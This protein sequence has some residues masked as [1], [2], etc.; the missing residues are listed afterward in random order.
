MNR[1]RCDVL[2]VIMTVVMLDLFNNIVFVEASN[3]KERRAKKTTRHSNRRRSYDRNLQITI[4]PEQT[5]VFS[6][7]STTS[8]PTTSFPTQ[9]P[10]FTNTVTN[11]GVIDSRSC[12]FGKGRT[13]SP[14][15]RPSVAPSESPS[16]SH[17][18]TI[19]FQPSAAPTISFR[20]ST[21]PSPDPTPQPSSSPS[22]FPTPLPSDAPSQRPT[23]SSPPTII[24][25]A[26]PSDKPSKSPTAT[27]TISSQPTI[28]GNPSIAPVIDPNGV[29]N[30][31][32]TDSDGQTG[33]ETQCRRDIPSTASSITDQLI[34]YEYDLIT[35]PGTDVTFTTDKIATE[36]QKEMSNQFLKCTF[37]NDATTTFDTHTI[38][39]L[40]VDVAATTQTNCT[41]VDGT[42]ADCYRINA[43][44]TATIF[45]LHDSNGRRK[46]QNGTD[47]TNN[48]TTPSNT[49]TTTT[50][51]TTSS[52]S[53]SITDPMV[54]E[55]FSS[56]LQSVFES[57]RLT[58][59]ITNVKST[60]FQ[61]IVNDDS[62][63]TTT[64]DDDSGNTT[65][66]DDDSDTG[67]Q[68]DKSLSGGKVAGSVIGTLI[69]V[70]IIAA[71]IAFFV[72]RR[73]SRDDNNNTKNRTMDVTQQDFNDFVKN[74][75]YDDNNDRDDRAM[76]DRSIIASDD[77]SFHSGYVEK[78]KHQS[79]YI[80]EE[81]DQD[82]YY[83]R[84]FPNASEPS[85]GE[86]IR[87]A[88]QPGPIFVKT[89]EVLY[90]LNEAERKA[91][92]KIDAELGTSNVTVGSRRDYKAPDTVQL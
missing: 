73:H 46:L 78:A 42:T 16:I 60:E 84:D 69:A 62:G 33:I 65:T 66:P 7:N 48:S 4:F 74:E 9:S 2:F 52:P 6:T 58:S 89:N 17:M 68:S 40:P 77:G 38:S 43:A 90:E 32:V 47:T 61:G 56:S 86:R 50:T 81:D 79:A 19:S 87:S 57:G 41:T 31:I 88:S 15:S 36:I 64:P 25:S 22:L 18:P 14:S 1:M 83:T 85:F 54:Y 76:I 20:P 91:T 13:C 30:R 5:T 75:D 10:V 80:I 55:S 82:T 92:S 11:V 23:I 35:A 12:K 72:L 24:P 49:T 37:D 29:I 70:A 67:S 45:Y 28:T 26:M 59:D 27:P 53:D 51:T 34:V 8:F 39:S 3:L 63:N 21:M 71:I 44:F